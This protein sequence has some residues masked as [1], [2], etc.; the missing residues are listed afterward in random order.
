MTEDAKMNQSQKSDGAP[1]SVPEAHPR[2]VNWPGWVW[3]VPIAAALL[4]GWFVYQYWV[5]G[6]REVTVRFAEAPGVTVGAPVQYKGI[7]VGNVT[8]ISLGK[9]LKQVRL[10]VLLNGALASHIGKQTKFWIVQPKLTQGDVRGLISGAHL[11]VEPGG[12]PKA[13]SFQGLEAPPASAMAQAGRTF[14]LTATSAEGLTRGAPVFY[15][16]VKVGQVLGTRLAHSQQSV[17]VRIVIDRDHEELVRKGT[18]FWQAGGISISTAGGINLHVPPLQALLTGA[19]AFD[20]PSVFAGPAAQ[21]GASFVLHSGRDSAE[22]TMQGAR[23]AYFVRFPKVVSG[24]SSGAAVELDGRRIGRVTHVGLEVDA[25]SGKLASPVRIQIDATKLGLDLKGAKSR[26]DVRRLLDKK[27]AALVQDGLRAKI[28]SGGFL[29][30]GQ[31]VELTIVKGAA[32]ATLDLNHQPP[33]IPPVA[34][35]GQNQ[36][37][38]QG[39]GSG[40]NKGSSGGSGQKAGQAQTGG[41]SG[42]GSNGQSGAG[43][44]A[45]GA[46]QSGGGA[47]SSQATGTTK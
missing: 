43:G 28:S 18:V 8:D 22:A 20:T 29:P 33:A 42:S 14:L 47:G 11:G 44:G 31:A 21:A 16:G 30:G 23:F 12:G 40:G 13:S 26:E 2:R 27:L 3:L 25:K 39:G 4:A 10:K 7:Q 32:Q 19:V 5:V 45:S 41:Q 24:V 17:E 46:A 15:R 1:G 6:A 36:T 34:P 35:K 9:T 38:N 37:Q